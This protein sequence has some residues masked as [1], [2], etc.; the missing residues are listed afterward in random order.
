VQFSVPV[1]AVSDDFAPAFWAVHGEIGGGGLTDLLWTATYLD[2]S[3]QSYMDGI[4][5]EPSVLALLPT[6]LLIL[7]RRKRNDPPSSS[8]T[9]PVEQEH[10]KRLRRS[11]SFDLLHK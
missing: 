1:T 5:P 4:I 11:V 8:K 6:S 2:G 10:W 7:I 9:K 3:Q